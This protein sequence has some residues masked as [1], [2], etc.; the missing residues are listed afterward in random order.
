MLLEVGNR[1]MTQDIDASFEGGNAPLIR[2]AVVIVVQRE[3]LARDWLNDE[4]KGFLYT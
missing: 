4:A 3:G 1:A 2:E